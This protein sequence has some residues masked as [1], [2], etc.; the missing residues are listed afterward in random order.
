MNKKDFKFLIN[1]NREIDRGCQILRV[2]RDSFLPQLQLIF[3][4]ASFGMELSPASKPEKVAKGEKAEPKT[5][6]VKAAKEKSSGQIS[7]RERAGLVLAAAEKI[8]SKGEARLAD[9]MK[10]PTVFPLVKDLKKPLSSVWKT[11]DDSDT[12]ERVKGKPGFY[13][14]K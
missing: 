5:K 14:L 3:E 8:L 12:V 6:K 10:H 11:F 7:P 1:L 4:A 2:N 13:K 9:V